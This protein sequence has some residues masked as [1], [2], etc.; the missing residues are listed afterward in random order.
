MILRAVLEDVSMDP[1]LGGGEVGVRKDLH[2]R[3]LYT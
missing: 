3:L 2:R 1:W